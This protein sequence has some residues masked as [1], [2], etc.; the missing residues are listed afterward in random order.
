MMG[1]DPGSATVVVE[2]ITKAFGQKVAVGDVTC[3]FGPGVTGLLGPNGAGKTTLLRMIAGLVQPTEGRI[4]VEGLNP[5]EDHRA[6]RALGFVAEDEAVY[7]HLTAKQFI[8]F[9]AI[10]AGINDPDQ[11]VDRVLSIVDMTHAADRKLAGFSK[12]MRQRTKVAAALVHK[13]RVLLLDEPLNGADPVQRAS[14]IELFQ[15]LGQRGYTVIVSSHVLHEVERVADTIIAITDGQLA[16]AGD[17]RSLRELM[18]DIP[19]AILVETDRPRTMASALISSPFA[20][21]V[22]VKDNRVRVETSDAPGLARSVARLARDSDAE[23]WRVEPEDASL[24]SVF[25]YLVGGP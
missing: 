1:M 4:T 13:P 23:L 12:G 7:N 14:L 24:E 25:R 3:S 11:D 6:M 19:Q 18:T 17:V 9:N 10:L 2:H 20:S 15:T 16:A 8:R 5:N 21:A 22:S